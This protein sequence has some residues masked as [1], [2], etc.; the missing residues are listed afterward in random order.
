MPPT[1]SFAGT[2][3]PGVI[4]QLEIR[5]FAAFG[6]GAGMEIRGANLEVAVARV[7]PFGIEVTGRLTIPDFRARPAAEWGAEYNAFLKARGASHLAATV[8]LPRQDV[9]VRQISLPGVSGEDLGAAVALQL[10]TLHP[11]GEDDIH[12]GWTRF[13]GGAVLI[14]IL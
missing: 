13:G 9:I 3:M 1:T 5:K 2:R 12:Y 10:D 4:D 11:Y 8:L 7:R 6:T 14:G